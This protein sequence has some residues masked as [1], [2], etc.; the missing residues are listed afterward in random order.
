LESPELD[1][2]LSLFIFSYKTSKLPLMHFS[3]YRILMF[4]FHIDQP[5]MLP[6]P[7]EKNKNLLFPFIFFQLEWFQH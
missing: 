2:V 1:T 4:F 5:L 7:K 6:H 3:I